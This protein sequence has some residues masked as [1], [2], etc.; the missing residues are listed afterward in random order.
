VA[1]VANVS[2][3]SGKKHSDFMRSFDGDKLALSIFNNKLDL[4]FSMIFWRFQPEI[5]LK[6]L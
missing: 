2:E 3:I 6:S 4:K 1:L 5:R